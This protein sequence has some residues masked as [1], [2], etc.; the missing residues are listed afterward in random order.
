MS[1]NVHKKQDDRLQFKIT[2]AQSKQAKWPHEIFL[3]N[4]VFNHIFVFCAAMGVVSTFPLAALVTPIISFCII[5]YILLKGSQVAK[6]DADW[7]VKA[8]WRVGTRLNRFFLFLLIGA[9][10]IA[11][12]GLY[13]SSMLHW[14][15]ITTMALIVGAG[16]LPFMVCLLVLV[17]MGND[18]FYMGRY[19]KLPKN[20]FEKYPDL[21][22]AE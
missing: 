3:I 1:E 19:G 5:G 13:L 11:G 16:L 2:E 21:K 22:P 12:G 10:T 7:F 4:L 20:F 9:C 15:K 18:W 14:N 17:V 6:S 8:H